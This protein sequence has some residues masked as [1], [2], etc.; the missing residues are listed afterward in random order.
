VVMHT[1]TDAHRLCPL[2]LQEPQV[3]RGKDGHLTLNN[4]NNKGGDFFSAAGGSGSSSTKQSAFGSGAAGSSSRRG[5]QDAQ[6]AS[7]PA[8]A[9]SKFGNAKAISSK[10]F[11]QVSRFVITCCTCLCDCIRNAHTLTC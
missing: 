2:V 4:M 11:Q 5:T 3:Q 9:Q 7:E 1:H 6:G 10:D 8:V